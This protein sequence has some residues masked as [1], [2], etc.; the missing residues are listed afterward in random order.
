[1]FALDRAA[2]STTK[3]MIAAAAGIPALAKTVTNGLAV[4]S[5]P[6]A[7]TVQGTT[8]TITSTARM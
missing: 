4:R 1:V 5:P 8:V 7:V 6:W 2:V 3:F